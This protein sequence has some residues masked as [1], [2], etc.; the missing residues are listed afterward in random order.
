MP[1]KQEPVKSFPR[2]LRMAMA[3]LGMTSADL[4]RKTTL[5]SGQISNY[6]NGHQEPTVS[7]LLHICEGLGVSADFLLGFSDVIRLKKRK[8]TND[9]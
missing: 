4:V 3:T 2:R 9:E 5:G 7:S 1:R 8:V 6:L